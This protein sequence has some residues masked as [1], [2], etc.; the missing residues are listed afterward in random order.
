MPMYRAMK[1]SF[2]KAARFLLVGSAAVAAVL[3]IGGCGASVGN[4]EYVVP[5]HGLG[6]PNKPL[7]PGEWNAVGVVT[8]V[9][10]P[11]TYTDEPVGAVLHR[12]WTF[13]ES[14]DS[15]CHKVFFRQTLY[16]P[17]ETT[18]VAS[19]PERY[20]AS[21]PP[22]VVPCSYT[23]EYESEYPDELHEA[24]E[25]HDEYE[26]WWSDHGT[27]AHAIEHTQQSGCYPGTE[28]PDTIEWT[29]TREGSAGA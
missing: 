3:A 9:G 15:S 25:S 23:R 21:F 7:P 1:A 29:A 6:L 24:G 17:S 16:G 28:P 27:V 13:E 22:V 5:N 20:A 19:G 14:C 10:N 8:A 2:R 18:L 12:P 26:V 4:S 11:S